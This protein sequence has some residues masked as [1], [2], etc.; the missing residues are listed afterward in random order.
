MKVLVLI[1]FSVFLLSGVGYAC[2]NNV[3]CGPGGVCIKS[4][5]SGQGVCSNPYGNTYRQ[6]GN[7]YYQ[8]NRPQQRN[9]LNSHAGSRCYSS[10][11]CGVGGSC[12]KT[13]HDVNGVCTQ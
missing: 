9:V 2:W 13:G 12:I 4:G 6:Q 11:D 3:D 5:Y 10:L 7:T 8:D 1:I